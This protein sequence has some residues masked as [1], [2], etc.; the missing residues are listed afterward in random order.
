MV[1]EDLDRPVAVDRH[2][3]HAV[4]LGAARLAPGRDQRA[5]AAP[6]PEPAVPAAPVA[7]PRRRGRRRLALVGLAALAWPQP[8]PAGHDHV[9]RGA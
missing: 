9:G 8:T 4:A 3:E 7:R 6:D 1:T 5:A 2:P